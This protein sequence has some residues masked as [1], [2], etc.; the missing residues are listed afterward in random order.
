[1]TVEFVNDHEKCGCD[2]SQDGTLIAWIRYTRTDGYIVD[3]EDD[4]CL[5]IGE[6]RKIL[7]KMNELQSGLK[8]K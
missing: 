8:S 2:V 4:T 5:D 6:M 1:M 7:D 3:F